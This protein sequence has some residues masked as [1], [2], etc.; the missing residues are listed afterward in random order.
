[1]RGAGRRAQH[2]EVE[3]PAGC[4]PARPGGGATERNGTSPRPPGRQITNSTR[5]CALGG[6]QV[7]S[8]WA[9]WSWA[10]TNT[11]PRGPP[12]GRCGG[13]EQLPGQCGRIARVGRQP[14]PWS[15]PGQGAPGPTA[16]GRL[17]GE[18]R[19]R[20]APFPSSPSLPPPRP[21]TSGRGQG[22]LEVVLQVPA[23]LLPVCR[24]EGEEETARCPLDD[25]AVV[26]QTSTAWASP[27]SLRCTSRSVSI[28]PTPRSART[29]RVAGVREEHPGR[30]V[31][32]YPQ[33]RGTSDRAKEPL[34]IEPELVSLR[35]P[36]P[37]T[38]PSSSW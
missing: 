26:Q 28:P 36:S 2:V 6:R 33:S 7:R 9:G 15:R 38:S 25:A 20:T 4:G 35:K 16:P 11:G 19:S 29:R 27:A 3:T 34:E 1:M 8:A 30:G 13:R 23:Q 37:S 5:S 10:R 17:A 12:P 22:E 24:A 18:D 31:A 14:P 21:P 32:G